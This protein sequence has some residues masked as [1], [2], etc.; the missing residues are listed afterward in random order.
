MSIKHRAKSFQNVV[1]YCLAILVLASHRASPQNG[2]AMAIPH[3]DDK[4]SKLVKKLEAGQT[5]INYQ[6][7]R[8]SFLE[9]NQ[10]K[11]LGEQKPDLD[12]LRNTMH[13]LMNKAKYPEV[14]DVAKKM[15]SIDYTDMEAHKILQQT[16]KILGDT[17]DRNKYHEIEFGLLN[18]IVKKG[19]GKTCQTAWP[20]IQVREEYFILDMIGAKVLQQNIVNTGGLCDRMQVQTDQGEKVYYFETSR[21]FKGYNKRGIH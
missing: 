12:T 5:N 14:I 16:Y 9:S 3:D 11:I 8:E 4:Y 6:E 13:E 18:S 15:L 20:V 10:F 7:F 21:V 17:C 2:A 19:D 1:F